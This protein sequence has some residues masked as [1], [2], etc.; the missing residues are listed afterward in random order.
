[1]RAKPGLSGLSP[2]ENRDVP[3]LRYDWVCRLKQEQ[4]E[5]TIVLNGGIT[6]VAEALELLEALDGVM[7]GRAAYHTPWMLAELQAELF[8]TGGPKAASSC[9]IMTRYIGGQVPRE[10]R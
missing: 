1:M 5:L 4:P 10:C 3:E 7:L 9:G 6:T 2:K 8:G